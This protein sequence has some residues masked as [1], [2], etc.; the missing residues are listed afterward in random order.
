MV[1]GL[2]IC[3]STASITTCKALN[4]EYEYNEVTIFDNDNKDIYVGQKDFSNEYEE[5]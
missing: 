2:N 5:I 3:H 4:I 1:H